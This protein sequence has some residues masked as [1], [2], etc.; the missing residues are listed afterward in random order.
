MTISDIRGLPQVHITLAN[1]DDLN[2][3]TDVY[4]TMKILN[5]YGSNWAA[6]NLYDGYVGVGIA[7]NS[8]AEALKKP[9]G[10]TTLK[11]PTSSNNDVPL[12]GMAPWRKWRLLANYYDPGGLRNSFA[13][14]LG[15][16]LPI[17]F[18]SKSRP[19]EV[20][21]VIS[22]TPVYQGLYH[23]TE[24]VK[25]SPGRVNV[26]G[27]GSFIC[28][29]VV[30]EQMTEDELE[31]CF[32]TPLIGA[33]AGDPAHD[34]LNHSFLVD[35]K[36]SGGSVASVST[37]I[38][39]FETALVAAATGGNWT[40]IWRDWMDFNSTVAF[41]VWQ[42]LIKSLDG[43]SHGYR[44][45]RDNTSG[46]F[47]GKMFFAGWDFDLSQGNG[48][49]PETLVPSGFWMSY[50]VWFS[51]FLLDPAFL[52]AV[53]I[54]FKDWLPLFY[55]CIRVSKADA[56]KLTTIGALDR[57]FTKW[58]IADNPFLNPDLDTTMAGAITRHQTWLFNR[59]TAL[60]QSWNSDHFISA[61]GPL[62][63]VPLYPARPPQVEKLLL[64][65]D[66][67]WR[68]SVLNADGF[69]A[70]HY[71]S[72]ASIRNLADNTLAVQP[73]VEAQG[74]YLPYEG[75][76]YLFISPKTGANAYIAHNAVMDIT[77]EIT[78]ESC[79]SPVVWPPPNTQTIAGRYASE[80]AWA[81][82]ILPDGKLQYTWNNS[83]NVQFL[84]LSTIGIPAVSNKIWV[85][86]YRNSGLIRFYTSNDG[87]IWTQ[88]GDSVVTDMGA[89]KTGSWALELGSFDSG[90]NIY[91]L[92]GGL[93]SF[94]L[95]NGPPSG[96]TVVD[97][98]AS[99][100]DHL[101]YSGVERANSL[102]VNYG[103]DCLLIGRGY[104]VKDPERDTMTYSLSN[105]VP[106]PPYYTAAIVTGSLRN[107]EQ[108]ISVGAA[109]GGPESNPGPIYLD[110]DEG[111]FSGSG[112]VY[113]ARASIG[114]TGRRKIITS[115]SGGT[116]NLRVNGDDDEKTA[117]TLVSAEPL[118]LLFQRGSQSTTGGGISR[119][120][121]WAT[122]QSDEE[123]DAWLEK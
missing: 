9:L 118:A 38:N 50:N 106:P 76:K 90:N 121:L 116:L 28:E 114:G 27:S 58:G 120:A 26:S 88:L 94:R 33:F 36:G 51:R 34:D 65:F 6:A 110:M 30:D 67:N 7:G 59:I 86:F 2:T 80:G 18:T 4:G 39:N 23:L 91:K 8:T 47:A 75:Y 98:R 37:Y 93:H 117:L 44:V 22:G 99:D 107:E 113:A 1:F 109:I 123:V 103:Y 16:K 11:N 92:V 70:G 83:S 46:I 115:Y 74:R 41:Y 54:Q 5:G 20:Y 62:R 77:G 43:P 112:A 72:V 21:Y 10:L 55:H 31:D 122:E 95:V 68:S 19:V 87:I 82:L 48:G 100:S 66:F 45:C 105:P 13:L 63:V 84:V 79:F 29:A 104:I 17:P 71:E 89:A 14:A 60:R 49:N 61:P 3:D 35:Y 73:Q 56:D 102:S 101:D 97:W 42:E 64:W 111:L 40:A 15:R 32:K 53:K 96:T 57:E 24:T 81:F 69:P 12:L 85:R 52:T 78:I 25:Q 119:F 108:L